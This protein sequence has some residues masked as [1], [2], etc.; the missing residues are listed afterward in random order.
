MKKQVKVTTMT[1]S[2]TIQQRSKTSVAV[3]N[4]KNLDGEGETARR[5]TI[6]CA[7]REWI[8]PALVRRFLADCFAAGDLCDEAGVLQMMAPRPSRR[9][10]RGAGSLIAMNSPKTL[11]ESESRGK[12]QC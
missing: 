9:A 6:A 7:T 12:V 5:E 10:R 2:G 8:I 3:P 1:P 11:R 4:G